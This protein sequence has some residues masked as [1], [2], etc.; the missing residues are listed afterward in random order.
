[1]LEQDEFAITDPREISA[2]LERRSWVTLVSATDSGPVVSHLPLLVDRSVDEI[3]VV[4]HLARADATVHS[5][6]KHPVVIVAEGANGY[7]SPSWYR[8]GPFVPTWNFVVVHLHGRPELLDDA[9]TWQVLNDTCDHFE[10]ARA[11]PW[12]MASVRAY[13]EE[14]APAVTGFRLVPTRVVAK[15]KLSQDKSPEIVE[16]VIAALDCDPVHGN[17]ELAEAMRRHLPPGIS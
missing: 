16:R 14:L 15:A 8:D 12:R 2:I 17:S 9:Q 1:M 10:D 3:A 6:G 13:A 5:L 11:E 7:V 4:G